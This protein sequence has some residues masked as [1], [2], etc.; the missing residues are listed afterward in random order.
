[1]NMKLLFTLA[2]VVLLLVGCSNSPVSG[3]E[4]PAV[5]VTPTATVETAVTETEV[6]TESPTE[7][8]TA[9]PEPSPTFTETATSVP[10]PNRPEYYPYP[11]PDSWILDT[12]DA[13]K[14]NHIIDGL[15]AIDPRF[16]DPRIAC[17]TMYEDGVA[18]GDT[19]IC[20]PLYP[21]AG[22]CVQDSEDYPCDSYLNIESAIDQGGIEMNENSFVGG[23]DPG[24]YFTGYPAEIAE[25]YREVYS[26]NLIGIPG[27]PDSIRY[28][29]LSEIPL[30]SSLV[31]EG[32]LEEYGIYYFTDVTFDP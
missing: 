19:G 4:T 25:I 7:T 31:D 16:V 22:F 11:E 30:S 18:L 23:M 6:P 2:I 29:H 3:T 28:L 14:A 10:V 27:D 24:Y 12:I 13:E 15:L 9:T 8:V 17:D 21:E 5:E 20:L 26:L 1:M 32:Y